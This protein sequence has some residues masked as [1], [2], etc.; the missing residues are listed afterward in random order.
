M[1]KFLVLGL[2]VCMMFAFSSCKSK[3]ESAYKTAY[4]QAKQQELAQGSVQATDA[5]EIAPVSTTTGTAAPVDQSYR[6]EKVVLAVGEQGSLKAFS[7]V[8][9][10][11]SS[12][13][14]AEL[15][16]NNLISEGYA[17]LVVQN[18]STGLYRVVCA[19]YDDR[20]KAAEARAQFKANHP[21]DADFQK[22]WLLYNK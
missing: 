11:F 2:G 14:N 7:V 22:A 4:D 8:C 15:V 10:S 16:R 20:Q 9:G 13:T 19:S 12:K 18:P 1:K 6:E 5:V 17:A 3:K 21:G